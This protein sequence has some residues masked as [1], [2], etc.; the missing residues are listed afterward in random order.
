MEPKW[1]LTGQQKK[2]R[3]R[4]LIRK[5]KMKAAKI[6]QV[7]KQT[8]LTTGMIDKKELTI[9]LQRQLKTLAS[10]QDSNIARVTRSSPHSIPTSTTTSADSAW[11]FKSEA[12]IKSRTLP[13]ST[14]NTL[15]NVPLQLDF[16]TKLLQRQQYATKS[17]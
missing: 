11:H 8:S 17:G 15:E 9:S 10:Q 6:R 14:S 13:L 16:C 5:G 12:L 4:N 2:F 3:F 7:L 1:V